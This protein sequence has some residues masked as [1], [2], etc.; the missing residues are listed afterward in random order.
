MFVL[1]EHLCL[2]SV[3]K[4]STGCC[5]ALLF[6]LVDSLSECGVGVK[7]FHF[8]KLYITLQPRASDNNTLYL[9]GSVMHTSH[10]AECTCAVLV[11]AKN[12]SF[13]AKSCCNFECTVLFF[14]NRSV[15]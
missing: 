10:S 6:L 4:C 9:L 2:L 14:V 11:Q 13:A 3:F 7:R 15:F 1:F 12:T 5:P 8:G